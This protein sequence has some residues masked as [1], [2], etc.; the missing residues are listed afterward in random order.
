M[1]NSYSINKNKSDGMY[2]NSYIFTIVWRRN[3]Y[4]GRWRTCI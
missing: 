2:K 3:D 4:I 1:H